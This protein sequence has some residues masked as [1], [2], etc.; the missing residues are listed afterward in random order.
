MIWFSDYEGIGVDNGDSAIAE[1]LELMFS[2]LFVSDYKTH[3]DKL[4]KCAILS[5]P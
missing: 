3:N 4:F 2:N 5:S 1:S